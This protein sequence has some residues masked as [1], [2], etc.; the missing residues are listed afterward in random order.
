MNSRS[1]SSSRNKNFIQRNKE[2]I[3]R[4]TRQRSHT[5]P[6]NLTHKVQSKPKLHSNPKNSKSTQD[7]HITQEEITPTFQDQ[8]EFQHS[9]KELLHTH[10]HTLPKSETERPPSMTPSFQEL[11]EH[12][13]E[14]IDTDHTS[15]PQHEDEF[16]TVYEES[17]ES[18]V[19]K[20]LASVRNSITSDRKQSIPDELDSIPKAESHANENT[21]NTSAPHH[22]PRQSTEQPLPKSV[23]PRRLSTP[24]LSSARQ[25]LNP[26][27]HPQE[28]IQTSGLII[29]EYAIQEPDIQETPEEEHSLYTEQIESPQKKRSSLHESGLLSHR[30]SSSS[31][32]SSTKD[33]NED[34]MHEL[35]IDSTNIRRSVRLAKKRNQDQT[36]KR[37]RSSLDSLHTRQS[38][39]IKKN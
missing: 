8:T 35:K 7:S 12:Q 37:K 34:E 16:P 24:I 39:K 15:S 38:K 4:I 33:E 23:T 1:N 14:V 28:E 3:T 17:Q 27:T 5:P 19:R 21:P 18:D 25:S 6:S 13:A 20:S 11:N 22:T 31:M 36:L 29:Q 30:V 32:R 10:T 26:S 9:Q 2:N